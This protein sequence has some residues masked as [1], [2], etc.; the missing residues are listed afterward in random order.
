[1]LAEDLRAPRKQRHTAHRI[2]VRLVTEYAAKVAEVMVPQVPDAGEEAGVDLSEADV[3]F[4]W[5]G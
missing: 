2:Y 5:G 4:S 1:M 3:D